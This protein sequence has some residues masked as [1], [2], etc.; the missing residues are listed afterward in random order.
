MPG[1]PKKV[2]AIQSQIARAAGLQEPLKIS[3]RTSA[4]L[5]VWEI[6]DSLNQTKYFP[7]SHVHTTSPEE[8][9]REVHQL[10][11]IK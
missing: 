5:I 10:T 4:N 2:I 1:K 8:G 9:W 7:R 11:K 6:T 3:P